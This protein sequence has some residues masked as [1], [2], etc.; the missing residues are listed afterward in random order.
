MMPALKILECNP[1]TG[2]IG[3][4]APITE[5]LSVQVLSSSS[6]GNNYDFG[7]ELTPHDASKFSHMTKRGCK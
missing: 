3:G 2:L 4:K 5:A 7:H 1:T 6:E